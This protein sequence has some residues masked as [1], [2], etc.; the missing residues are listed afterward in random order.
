MKQVDN[1][2]YS[3]EGKQMVEQTLKIINWSLGNLRV[4][5]IG[6]PEDR[7]RETSEDRG[8]NSNLS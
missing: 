1:G 3:K 4:C 6:S 7:I 8:W 2:S 5:M